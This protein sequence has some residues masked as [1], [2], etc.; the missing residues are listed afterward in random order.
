MSERAKQKEAELETL[1]RSM[2]QSGM[3]M[4][5]VLNYRIQIWAHCF[6][7]SLC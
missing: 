6:T 2:M 4:L 3:V 7:L 5:F 1:K